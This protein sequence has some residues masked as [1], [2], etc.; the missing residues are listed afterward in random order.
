[1]FGY[2]KVLEMAT[3]ANNNAQRALDA[4]A[5]HN[6]TCT[7][8]AATYQKSVD[9]LHRR[10]DST[11]DAIKWMQRGIIVVLLTIIGGVLVIIAPRLFGGAG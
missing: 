1:M 5:Q 10:I 9:S 2:G 6:Q 7:E 3:T 4:I 11:S 8:R